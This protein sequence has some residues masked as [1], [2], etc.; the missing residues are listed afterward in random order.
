MR[1]DLTE[2]LIISDTGQIRAVTKDKKACQIVGKRRFPACVNF[3]GYYAR[4]PLPINYSYREEIAW[5]ISSER[6]AILGIQFDLLC[7]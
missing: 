4:Y 3:R 7:D 5:C 1:F 2:K 6:S